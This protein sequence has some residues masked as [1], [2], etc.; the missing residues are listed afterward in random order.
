MRRCI[1]TRTA[2][3]VWVRLMWGEKRYTKDGRFLDR[4]RY[5]KAEYDDVVYLIICDDFRHYSY[6]DEED[7]WTTNIR[8]MG[9]RVDVDHI[10]FSRVGVG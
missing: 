5:S 4:I 2:R 10:D 1:L 7:K 6:I 8:E 9:K 3:Y